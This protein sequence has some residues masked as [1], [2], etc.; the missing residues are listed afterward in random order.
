MP[1]ISV[2]SCR[3]PFH[4]SAVGRVMAL[5]AFHGAGASPAQYAQ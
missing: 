2:P 1:R 5:S 3:V 4:V